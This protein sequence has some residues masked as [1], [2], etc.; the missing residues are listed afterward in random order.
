MPELYTAIDAELEQQFNNLTRSIENWFSERRTTKYSLI[1]I[2]LVLM[3]GIGVLSA[4]LT[5]G[6][7]LEDLVISSIS[8]LIVKRVIDALNP[9]ITFIKK[10]RQRFE[11][12]H[13]GM[14]ERIFKTAVLDYF[15]GTVFKGI[16]P[17]RVEKIDELCSKIQQ[18]AK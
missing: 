7:G 10:E 4:I 13:E 14:F 1:A 9:H 17:Y 8:P 18:A 11:K 16:T 3:T 15:N 12:I 5:G 6:I 2:K